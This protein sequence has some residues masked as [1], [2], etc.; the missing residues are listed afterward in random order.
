MYIVESAS[1]RRIFIM[2]CAAA[3]G[4]FSCY[5]MRLSARSVRDAVLY[6]YNII[7]LGFKNNGRLHIKLR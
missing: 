5:V 7:H 6:K 1:H 2:I 4:S 3:V